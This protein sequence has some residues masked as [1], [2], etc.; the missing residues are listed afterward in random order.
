MSQNSGSAEAA[1][2]LKDRNLTFFENSFLNF[3]YQKSNVD[4]YFELT[5]N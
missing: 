3:C 1:L 5:I 4:E 2:R